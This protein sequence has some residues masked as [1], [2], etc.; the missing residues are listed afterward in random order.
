MRLLKF[1]TIIR[2]LVI[3]HDFIKISLQGDILPKG[4]VRSTSHVDMDD[5]VC[6]NNIPVCD[7]VKHLS[8]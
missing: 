8:K 4:Y 5:S 6:N 1:K 7:E 2:H 3:C